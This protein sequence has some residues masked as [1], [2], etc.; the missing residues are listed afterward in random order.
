[1]GKVAMSVSYSVMHDR[2]HTRFVSFP[3]VFETWL[4]DPDWPHIHDSPA[5]TPLRSADTST[6]AFSS[7]LG[8]IESHRPTLEVAGA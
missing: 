7:P 1:M 6:A 8:S 5:S 4:E 3:T 2:L